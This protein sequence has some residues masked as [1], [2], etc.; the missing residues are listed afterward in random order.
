M[1]ATAVAQM[2]LAVALPRGR[3][4]PAWALSA[5]ISAAVATQQ[6]FGALVT[7]AT[8]TMTGPALDADTQREV[9]LR[10]FRAQARRATATPYY[11]PLFQTLGLNPGKLTWEEIGCSR[12][13]G[14]AGPSMVG[15]LPADG[16]TDVQCIAH[17]LRPPH[18]FFNTLS[19]WLLTG[20]GGRSV[21]G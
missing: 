1:L 15:S 17:R 10:R 8:E 19:Y 5:L 18:P 14:L 4:I 13:R 20:D 2:R 11:G 3:P 12:R 6:E 9:Q 16:V 21:S 7:G